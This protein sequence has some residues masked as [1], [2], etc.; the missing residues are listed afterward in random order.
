LD[1][2]VTM[3]S[4]QLTLLIK[5]I[6]KLQANVWMQ[7]WFSGLVHSDTDPAAQLHQQSAHTDRPL[8]KSTEQDAATGSIWFKTT[9]PNSGASVAV[10]LYSSSTA[11]WNTVS[12][13]LYA[14]NHAAIYGLDP[15]NGGTRSS[16]RCSIHSVQCG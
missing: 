16:N 6:T 9:T 2:L 10:K 11:S 3:R 13:P 15:V 14:T 7:D 8:W 1:Q 5:H 4:T 12:A